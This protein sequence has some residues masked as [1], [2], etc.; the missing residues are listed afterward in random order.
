MKHMGLRRG[1]RRLR[2]EDG[3]ATIEFVVLF[4]LIFS[5]FVSSVDFSIQMLRQIFLDRAVDMTIRDVRLGRF[6]TNG[7][8]QMKES[9]CANAA[10]TPNCMATVTVE[11]RP[12]TAQELATLDP[13]AQ[14]VN[15]AANVTPVLS[16]TPGAGNQELMMLRACT[17]SN[18]FIVANGFILGNPRGPN[19]DF[20]AASIGIFVNEP[21]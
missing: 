4:P 21:R 20:M 9:I 18:P 12:V 14:C 2:A 13:R 10:L 6:D 17:V 1:L 15:R 8:D 19:D 3:N 7:L 16:F 11:L 5:I